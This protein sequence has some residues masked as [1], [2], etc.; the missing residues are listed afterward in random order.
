VTTIALLER[1]RWNVAVA[2]GFVLG[3]VVFASLPV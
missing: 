2:F 1:I 3:A